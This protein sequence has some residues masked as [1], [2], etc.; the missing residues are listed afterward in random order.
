MLFKIFIDTSTRIDSVVSNLHSE[1]A[2]VV[3]Q[4][5]PDPTIFFLNGQNSQDK[6][7]WGISLFSDNVF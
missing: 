1:I 5:H 7:F 2:S 6:K 4:N 3:D